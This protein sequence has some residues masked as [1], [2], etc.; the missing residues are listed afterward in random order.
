MEKTSGKI[1]IEHLEDA[2]PMFQETFNSGDLDGLVSLF[3]PGAVLVPGP[4]QV[5]TGVD[6]IRETLA[7][8]LAAWGR[9]EVKV[10]SRHQMGDIALQTAEWTVE[11]ND[12]D[13]S[14]RTLSARPVHLFRRQPDG[15]WRFIID[16]AF[17]F[18]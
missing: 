7:G 4:G 3:E 13:G 18:G 9:F 8:F 16:N 1:R 15:S 14:P 5:A 2:A 17:P 6:A 12:P 11:N 10:L